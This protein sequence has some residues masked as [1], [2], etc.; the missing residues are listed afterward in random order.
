MVLRTV[1]YRHTF[2]DSCLGLYAYDMAGSSGHALPAGGRGGGG[3]IARVHQVRIVVCGGE[4]RL[5]P[6]AYTRPLFS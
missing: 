4:H 3:T 1:S 2:E 5:R 6:G